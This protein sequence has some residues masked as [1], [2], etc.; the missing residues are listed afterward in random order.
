[1]RPD[2]LF[3]CV[4]KQQQC[5]HI[6][7]INKSFLK[8]ENRNEKDS[9]NFLVLHLSSPPL[10]RH[11]KRHSLVRKLKRKKDPEKRS[12]P[13]KLLHTLAPH[14]LSSTIGSRHSKFAPNKQLMCPAFPLFEIVSVTLEYHQWLVYFIFYK[15]HVLICIS[16]SG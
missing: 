15:N 10:L 11:G 3:C 2:A 12:I 16:Y 9:V 5:S 8:K 6:H 14:S 7:K 4:S 1:M 13:L